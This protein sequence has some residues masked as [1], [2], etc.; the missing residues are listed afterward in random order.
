MSY[1]TLEWIGDSVLK[2]VL[3]DSL[4][5]SPELASWIN[6]EGYLSAARDSLACNATLE[7][8]CKNLGI[9]KFI[10]RASLSRGTWSPSPMELVEANGIAVK[11]PLPTGKI[12]ADVIESL[13]GLVYTEYQ[14]DAARE[15]VTDMGLIQPFETSSTNK[16]G[17]VDL[18]VKKAMVDAAADFTGRRSFDSHALVE[19]AFCHPTTLGGPSYQVCWALQ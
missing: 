2:M 10:M 17:S 7:G 6:T 3:S 12:C 19:E 4:I 5:Q 15:L 11:R 14:I 9:D 16:S 8:V 18:V 13:I 1:E